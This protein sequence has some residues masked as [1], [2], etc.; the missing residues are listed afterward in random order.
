MERTGMSM[1][2]LLAKKNI[3]YRLNRGCGRMTS[4]SSRRPKGKESAAEL[5]ESAVPSLK[6]ETLPSLSEIAEKLPET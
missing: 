6:P 1:S 5:R 3:W 4:K 2:S